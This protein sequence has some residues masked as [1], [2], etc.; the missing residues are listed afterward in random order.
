MRR[1]ACSSELRSAAPS[2]QDS[3]LRFAYDPV[4]L[5]MILVPE[6]VRGALLVRRN[7]SYTALARCP[8]RSVSGLGPAGFNIAKRVDMHPQSSCKPATWGSVIPP[9]RNRVRSLV[10]GKVASNWWHP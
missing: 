3:L 7:R 4:A 10:L 5:N 1:V 9:I 8:G 6:P 2:T